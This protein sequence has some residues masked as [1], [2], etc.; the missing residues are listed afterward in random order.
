MMM[1]SESDLSSFN[2]ATP[3]KVNV[4]GP[5]ATENSMGS[6]FQSGSK[7]GT[8]NESNFVKLSAS[9]SMKGKSG[10]VLVSGEKS[11]YAVTLH[12]VDKFEVL[13]N[14]KSTGKK[15][16]DGGCHV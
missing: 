6:F 15:N 16:Q 4:H 11:P 2:I 8:S 5:I 1:T 3:G 7:P 14:V 13:T 10:E 9:S 12:N